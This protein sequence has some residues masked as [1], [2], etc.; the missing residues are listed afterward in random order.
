WVD[1]RKLTQMVFTMQNQD[2]LDRL[3]FRDR[4]PDLSV[5][6]RC[7]DCEA[8]LTPCELEGAALDRCATHGVWFDEGELQRVLRS[9][10]DH[11]PPI[12]QAN[13][14]RALLNMLAALLRGHEGDDPS[15]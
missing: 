8:A 6:R 15:R 2:R 13:I 11:P 14:G 4:S 9:A 1:E 10:G 3:V 7:P 12:P 5:A